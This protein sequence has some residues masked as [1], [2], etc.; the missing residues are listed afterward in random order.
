[1]PSKFVAVSLIAFLVSIAAG[2]PVAKPLPKRPSAKGRNLEERARKLA[3]R[4]AIGLNLSEQQQREL[5]EI[6]RANQAKTNESRG[7]TGELIRAAAAKEPERVEELRAKLDDLRKI[8]SNSMDSLYEEL[9][10]ILTDE[11]VEL[12][13]QKRSAA[14]GPKAGKAAQLVRLRAQLDLTGE[15]GR[16]FDEIVAVHAQ[17]ERVDPQLQM[18][19]LGRELQRAR[20]EGNAQRAAELEKRLEEM[21]TADA[22]EPR[23]VY[24]KLESILDANQIQ[25]MRNFQ[26]RESQ[27]RISAADNTRNIFRAVKKVE[28]NDDQ[29][30]SIKRLERRARKE[31]P[32]LRSEGREAEAA[33]ASEL[34]A[35]IAALL[36]SEQVEQFEKNMARLGMM[37]SPK[38]SG[39]P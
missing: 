22:A 37:R 13:R 6:V 19:S 8:I 16:E 3:E 30:R 1:M 23:D 29:R 36:T 38:D 31:R 24:A 20:K 33:Y 7:I 18:K 32:K 34:R 12:L 14:R 2:Q 9:E 27:G 11:Q 15:Q 35:K 17:R 4:L 39:T 28:L 21:Q 26:E 25:I 10:S 5:S